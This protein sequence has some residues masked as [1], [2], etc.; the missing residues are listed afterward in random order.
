[1]SR[2]LRKRSISQKDLA[3]ANITEVTR[4]RREK[5]GVSCAEL[6]P[7]LMEVRDHEGAEYPGQYWTNGA[8]IKVRAA[9]VNFFFVEK[10]VG[11]MHLTYFVSSR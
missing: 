4:P 9:N 3:E 11:C 7:G 5:R 8:K 10:Y 2:W 1:M 6:D